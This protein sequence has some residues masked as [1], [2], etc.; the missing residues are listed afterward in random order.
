MKPWC[1]FFLLNFFNNLSFCASDTYESILSQLTDYALSRFANDTGLIKLER[2]LCSLASHYRCCSCKHECRL[3]GTCCI[4][5]YLDKTAISFE[6]YLEY[7][8]KETDVKSDIKRLPVLNINTSFRVEE[9]DMV[10][11]CRNTSSLYHNVCNFNFSRNDIPVLDNSGLIYRN[12]Y[13]ALCKNVNYSY[14]EY[15]VDSCRYLS[16]SGR[17][18]CTLSIKRESEMQSNYNL[19]TLYP[20]TSD[21][22]CLQFDQNMC[23]NSYLLPVYINSSKSVANPYCAKCLGARNAMVNNTCAQSFMVSITYN[24]PNILQLMVSYTVDGEIVLKPKPRYTCKSGWVFDLIQQKC[25]SVLSRIFPFTFTSIS[26]IFRNHQN[27]NFSLIKKIFT[28]VK[29]N[30]GKVIYIRERL[31]NTLRNGSHTSKYDNTTNS[32]VL[33]NVKESSFNFLLEEIRLKN[34]SSYFSLVYVTLYQRLPY[35]KLYGT[36]PER[37]FI[38]NKVCADLFVIDEDNF[39]ITNKC[40]L[41]Y[42]NNTYNLIDNGIYGLKI[43]NGVVKPFAAICKQY[44]LISNCSMIELNMSLVSFENSSILVTAKSQIF[45]FADNEYYPTENGVSICYISVGG[46]F[47]SETL[48]LSW[49]QAVQNIS[50]LVIIF[51]LSCSIMTEVLSLITYFSIQNLQ[52][53]PG[54]ILISLCISLCISDVIFLYIFAGRERNTTVCKLSAVMLH[55]FSLCVSTWTGVFTI[56]FWSTFCHSFRRKNSSSL[57]KKCSMTGWGVPLA[58][59]GICVAIDQSLGVVGYGTKYCGVINCIPAKLMAY[60]IP[61][62]F[63][64]ISNIILLSIIGTKFHR[65]NKEGKKFR[66]Q[67]A[68][69]TN[70]TRIISRLCLVLGFGELI[71]VLQIADNEYETA[72]IFNSIIGCIYGVIR[73]LRGCYVFSMFVMGTETRK[74]FTKKMNRQV[75]MKPRKVSKVIGPWRI[76]PRRIALRGIDPGELPSRELHPKN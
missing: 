23:L 19:K 36:A 20:D 68:R 64:T 18:K 43:V 72:I 26:P 58:L 39:N 4:D 55:Y 46:I 76:V 24:K 15:F 12:K 30:N 41:R 21:M 56:N 59:V 9:V 53:T 10:A 65:E 14:V 60:V 5:V 35:S 48:H 29:G 6:Q 42:Q 71:G 57:F 37:Y 22:N 74:W 66:P 69:S 2:Y 49:L 1:I 45:K 33:A 67:N 51:L 40:K 17:N 7:F 34:E 50:N 3:Y 73:S 61:T 52:N 75:L 13:C 25:T 47:N 54:K 70:Y 63:A 32:A 62:L 38:G 27:A 28:C 8:L 16:D 44:H 31:K 11:Q